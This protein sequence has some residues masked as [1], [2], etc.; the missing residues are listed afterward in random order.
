MVG[1]LSVVAAV[2]LVVAPYLAPITKASVPAFDDNARELLLSV[3]GGVSLVLGGLFY[4]GRHV[5]TRVGR[6]D[7]PPHSV[8]AEPGHPPEDV[9][10][11]PPSL[12]GDELDTV[13]RS[14]AGTTLG[15]ESAEELRTTLQSLAVTLLV[16][17]GD[18]DEDEA[19]TAVTEGMWTTDKRAAWFLGGPDAP[20]PSWWQRAAD[21]LHPENRVVRRARHTVAELTELEE[22]DT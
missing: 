2:V 18:F 9:V 10:T 7:T 21:W 8:T 17:G 15:P 13:V 11:A 20:R 5:Y 6:S 19:R 14:L 12:V 3:V 4:A 16:D 22:G 1:V